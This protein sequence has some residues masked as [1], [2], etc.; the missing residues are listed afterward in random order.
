MSLRRLL[1]CA[2]PLFLS[3][4][5]AGGAAANVTDLIPPSIVVAPPEITNSQTAHFEFSSTDPGV[6]F[7]CSRDGELFSTCESP[8]EYGSLTEGGHTFAVKTSRALEESSPATHDWSIDLT[9]PAVSLTSPAN[10]SATSDVTPLFAGSRGIDPGDNAEVTVRIWAGSDTNAPPL[11]TLLAVLDGEAWSATPGEAEALAAGSYSA[12]AQQADAAGNTG[13]STVSAFTI[14]PF[15]PLVTLATPS[16]GARTRERRPLFSGTA[17][18][19]TVV[20]SLYEGAIPSGTAAQTLSAEVDDDTGF[21]SAQ[22]E[23]DLA[24]G[25]YSAVAKQTNAVGTGSSNAVAFTIDTVPPAF[26]GVG[27]SQVVEQTSAAGAVASYGVPLADDLDPAPR[28]ECSPPSGAVFPVGVTTVS[29]TATDWAGNSAGMQFTV[30]VANTIG[31]GP[32]LSL[33]A[34]AGIGRVTLT[35][36]RPAEW[37]YGRVVLRRAR[38][39][40]S[41]WRVIYD[42]SAV[43]AYVDRGVRND[44]EYVYEAKTLDIAGNASP[45]ISLG[46]RPSAFLSPRWNAVWQRPGVLRWAAVRKA[47]Y[48]NVQLWRNGRKI[49]SKWPT[50]PRFGLQSRWRHDGRRYSLADGTYFVYAWPGFGPKDAARYGRLIGWTKFRVG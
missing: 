14:E 30:T 31:P 3:A 39:G 46:A 38:P 12:R 50:R 20:L 10:G 35:W 16:N 1:V 26:V 43:T 27:A 6:K 9:S 19:G 5:L 44:T 34:R 49:L 40:S 17:D 41:E 23:S 47:A 15:V 11:H 2:G 25:V 18:P 45:S 21:W 29:C 8:K 28:V 24:D 13:L 42:G 48:Y 33:R 32:L 22:P 7:F 36:T 37:D 4:L